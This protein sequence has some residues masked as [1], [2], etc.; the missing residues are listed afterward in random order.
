MKIDYVLN[1]SFV[2]FPIRT[3]LILVQVLIGNLVSSKGHPLGRSIIE[4]LE[5]HF[6]QTFTKI[7]LFWRRKS[8]HQI[9]KNHF[10]FPLQ[11]HPPPPDSIPNHHTHKPSL[12]K[13]GTSAQT[14]KTILQPTTDLASS[15]TIASI[16]TC[17]C[18]HILNFQVLGIL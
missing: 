14:L 10:P 15:I 18:S 3:L 9:A 13:I 8:G 1:S 17:R 12:I 16:Q 5:F 2:R 4:E 6:S 11:G 7:S